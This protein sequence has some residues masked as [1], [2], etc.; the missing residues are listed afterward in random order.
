MTATVTQT[1]NS[2][3][4]APKP[5]RIIGIVLILLGVVAGASLMLH[6][7]TC[8]P[9]ETITV[10]MAEGAEVHPRSEFIIG[11]SFPRFPIS[12]PDLV[13]RDR[14][15]SY[16]AVVDFEKQVDGNSFA[17]RYLLPRGDGIFY[18]AQE[19]IAKPDSWGLWFSIDFVEYVSGNTFYLHPHRRPFLIGFAIG[20]N[21]V[22]VLVGGIIGWVGSDPGDDY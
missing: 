15:S 1:S 14:R 21:L 17:V 10:L 19:T 20:I 5:L 12:V 22:L 4:K 2:T 13:E 11:N 6:L 8:P 7:W 18:T 3:K 16:T 9:R